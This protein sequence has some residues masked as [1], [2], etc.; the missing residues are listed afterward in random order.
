MSAPLK[1]ITRYIDKLWWRFTFS[2][3]YH[4]YL[5]AVEA[6]KYYFQRIYL[7]KHKTDREDKD[8]IYD[9][10]T[11]NQFMRVSLIHFLIRLEVLKCSDCLGY[12]NYPPTCDHGWRYW[13]Y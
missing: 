2:S 9:G 12:H 13:Q 6:I 5:V 1:T 4:Y 11:G 10:M 7:P 8:I 3:P